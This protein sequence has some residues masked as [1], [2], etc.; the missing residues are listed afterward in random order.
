MVVR[1]R[2]VRQ[3]GLAKTR[4]CRTLAA[5]L[6]MLVCI[7]VPTAGSAL[8]APAPNSSTVPVAEVNL[9]G[10]TYRVTASVFAEGTDGQVGT[11]GVQRSLDP[12]ERQSGG[13]SGV[14]RIVLPMGAGRH[15]GRRH[16]RSANRLRRGR[17][18]LLGGNRQRHHRRMH[19]G[20]SPRPRTALRA[21]QLVGAAEPARVQRAA[22]H[23]RPPSTPAT[24]PT[25]A[26][27]P[28]SAMSGY[29]IRNVYTY[30]AGIDLAGG[31][32]K[33][34]GLA[35]LRGHNDRHRHHALAGGHH[36][37]RSLRQ[38]ARTPAYRHPE[39]RP[40]AMPP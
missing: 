25:S 12:A 35:S 22:G 6:A 34:L 7:A 10:G 31:T 4:M 39:S 23:S 40:S 20:P 24:A 26:L 17:R 1:T 15:R 19:R 27:A 2:Q 13:A 28:V 21:R 18:A 36:A 5:A 32:W 9:G 3:H 38:R 8:A 29:D 37:R 11:A 30:A 16:L 33:A 14:H